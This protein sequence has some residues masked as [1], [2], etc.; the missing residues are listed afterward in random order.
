MG[1]SSVW[2][3]D[4]EK[5]KVLVFGLS[6]PELV[7]FPD[8]VWEKDPAERIPDRDKFPDIVKFPVAVFDPA[9]EMLKLLKL[10]ALIVEAELPF[11]TTVDVSGLKVPE[12]VQF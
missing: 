11:K 5:I 4:F 7:K 1:P 3:P 9:P 2:S 10:L 6:V 8:R 12:V